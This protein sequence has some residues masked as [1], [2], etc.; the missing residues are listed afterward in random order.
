MTATS[1][2]ITTIATTVGTIA[3]QRYVEAK[4]AYI[5]YCKEMGIWGGDTI[6]MSVP[7]GTVHD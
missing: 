6:G 2:T 4:L 7:G 1:D 5:K 3:A